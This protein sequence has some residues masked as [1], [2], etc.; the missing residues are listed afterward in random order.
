MPFL[1]PNRQQQSTDGITDY[2]K[3]EHNC[4]RLRYMMQCYFTVCQK[5]D[6]S[7]LNLL[8]GINS[9]KKW[10]K[11]F[12]KVKMDKLR[13]IGKQP[14]ESVEWVMKKKK[15]GKLQWEEFGSC[16]GVGMLV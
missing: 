10:R 7:Q 9:S 5:A 15:K 3:Y 1:P 8:H 6:I 11:K 16:R 14:Q 2:I 12:K 4:H 13:S